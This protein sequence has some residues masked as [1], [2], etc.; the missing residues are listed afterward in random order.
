MA[1]PEP[2]A[3]R[4]GPVGLGPWPATAA[5]DP[6]GV[7]HVG[8]V[9]TTELAQAY[10]TPLW[11]VDEAD[12]RARC[13]AY[14]EAF[15]GAEVAYASKAWCTLGI[16]QLVTQESLWVDVASGGELHTAH[17]AGVPMERV[18]FHGNNKSDEELRL[19]AELGVGRVV[20]DSFDE[21]DRLERI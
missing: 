2:D 8:G 10:G 14:R 13:R 6:L 15:V 12:L 19:A 16:L 18:L 1:A 5:R 9:P 21:F 3:V 4:P 11:V 7:L 17:V 20:V